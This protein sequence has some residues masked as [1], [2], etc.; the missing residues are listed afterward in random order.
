V[1][2]PGNR[3][4]TLETRY[5]AVVL[6]GSAGSTVPMSAI[7]GGLPEDFSLSIFIVQHLHESDGGLFAEHLQRACRLRV[8]VP[9]DKRPI[10]A[11]QVY[12][13][14][15]NYHM[16][17]ERNGTVAL[18]VDP[19][20]N[21][22]RPSIDV[23]FESAARVYGRALIAVLFSGANADGAKGMITVKEC[24]GLTMV[25]KPE[26]SEFPTMPQEAINIA[27][28]DHVKPPAEIAQLLVE[29]CMQAA[30]RRSRFG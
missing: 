25:Q 19:K 10:E 23:L 7:L 24:K 15:S 21:W 28:P 22:S 1:R 18:S 9:Y 27:R 20:V 17:V 2:K 6:G 16:L 30:Q 12:V 29:L 5:R 4:A 13:A 14:P 11:G 8:V 3:K 26:T